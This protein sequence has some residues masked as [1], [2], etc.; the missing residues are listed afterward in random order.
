[1]QLPVQWQLTDAPRT[2][3]AVTTTTLYTTTNLREGV[4]IAGVGSLAWS[5]LDYVP[6]VL[7]VAFC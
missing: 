3:D 1:M 6:G 2:D 4:I 5:D 7:F